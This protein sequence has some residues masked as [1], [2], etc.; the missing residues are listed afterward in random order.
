M[1]MSWLD[2]MTASIDM[3][4]SKLRDIAKTGEPGM[5]QSIE[6]QRVRCDWTATA[7]K[8]EL[9][10]HTHT[11]GFPG[12]SAVKKLSTCRR[13]R[14]HPWED[15]LEEEM[16]THSSILVWKIPWAGEPKGLQSMRSQR[17]GYDWETEHA[18]ARTHTLAI[19]LNLE[20]GQMKCHS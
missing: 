15:P 19:R 7:Y 18:C 10:T 1:L 14:F 17:V 12:G 11:Q 9:E 13:R 8:K 5:L 6:L 4:L 16:I 2:T 20:T 3:N